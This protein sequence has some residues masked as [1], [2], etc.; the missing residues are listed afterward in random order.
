MFNLNFM[1]YIN[2]KLNI[3][4][5]NIKTNSD[6]IKIHTISDNSGYFI[7]SF[8]TSTNFVNVCK[9]VFSVPSTSQCQEIVSIKQYAYGQLEIADGQFYFVGI[10]PTS[11]FPLYLNKITFGSNAADWSN[12]MACWSGT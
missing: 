3:I 10:D 12:K 1:D 7:I 6:D 4:S 2:V 5:S 9:Y 8:L 11:P